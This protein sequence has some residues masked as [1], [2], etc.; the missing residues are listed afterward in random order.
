M[1]GRNW[2]TILMGVWGIKN[3]K[4]ESENGRRVEGGGMK[5][6]KERERDTII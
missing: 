3:E 1:I 2:K 5:G 4:G 6:G